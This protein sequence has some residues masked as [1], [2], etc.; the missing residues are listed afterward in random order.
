L[1]EKE[2]AVLVG[3][4]YEILRALYPNQ[5][6]TLSELNLETQ[7]DQGN[8][9]RYIVE[10][11][12]CNILETREQKR[13]RGR[14]LKYIKLN[15]HTRRI[16]SSI[17]IA[18]RPKKVR[19]QEWQIEGIVTTLTDPDIDHNLRESVVYTFGSFMED[20]P[21]QMIDNDNVRKLLQEV[22]IRP[23]IFGEKIGEKLRD[24][25]DSVFHRLLKNEKGNLW[26]SKEL[27]PVLLQHIENPDRDVTIRIWATKRVGDI[28]RQNDKKLL[29][30]LTEFWFSM[31]INNK[32]A[33]EVKKQL[34]SLSSQNL[35]YKILE[36]TKS[37]NRLEK[38]KAEEL[39]KDIIANWKTPLRREVPTSKY[40]ITS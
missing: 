6:Y 20:Y 30:T 29:Y 2:L 16:I 38:K 10:L 5:E 25:V 39:L 19:P 1:N 24:S 36:K 37:K 12:D 4:R 14:P 8:L 7:L 31:D 28:A 22:V 27:Y 3:R 15:D 33:Q 40:R 17:I 34:L 26:A 18:A 9:S 35:F 11:E 23:N 32:L 21:E 13:E